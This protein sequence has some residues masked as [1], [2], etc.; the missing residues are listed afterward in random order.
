MKLTKFLMLA[1]I[2]LAPLGANAN[3]TALTDRDDGGRFYIAARGGLAMNFGGRLNNSLGGMTSIPFYAEFDPS[4]GLST[5][6]VVNEELW[7]QMGSPTP[8][9]GWAPIGVINFGD[10]KP[11]KDLEIRTWTTNFA[12]GG[13]LP[14]ANNIRIE[15]SWDRISESSYNSTPLLGG[16]VVTVGAPASMLLPD[17]DVI[18]MSSKLS[19]DIYMAMIYFDFFEGARGPG[20]LMPYIGLGIGYASTDAI[21]SAFDYSGVL[22]GTVLGLAFEDTATGAFFLSETQSNGFAAAAAAGF[23]YG[24]NRFAFLELGAKVTLAPKTQFKLSN[25][26]GMEQALVETRGAYSLY[27]SIL[28][29]L[30]FEF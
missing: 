6:Y 8:T 9:E 30:R 23:S 24:L 20:Q 17:L 12:I 13:V 2:G 14:N 21:V 11:Q 16:D 7:I 26:L 27:G 18:S 19:T 1:A 3:W 25:P 5:G 28:A 29:G 4:T 10:L 22:D 15:A